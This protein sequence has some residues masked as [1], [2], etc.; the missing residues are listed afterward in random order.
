MALKIMDALPLTQRRPHSL[1]TLPRVWYPP[2]NALV[3]GLKD[4]L[5]Q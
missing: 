5:P 1:Q 4:L 2:A 3:I